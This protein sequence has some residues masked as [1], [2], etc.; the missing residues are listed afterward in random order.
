[1]VQKPAAT[2]EDYLQSLPEDR[3]EVVSAVRDVI[4]RSL[5]DGYSEMASGGMITYGVPLERFP[6][7]TTSSR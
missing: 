6:T 7:R 5:P 2:A 1:M 4:V 3:R